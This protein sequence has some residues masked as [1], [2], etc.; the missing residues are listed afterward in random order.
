LNAYAGTIIIRTTF[1]ALFINVSPDGA[2]KDSLKYYERGCTM[3]VRRL[4]A[5][6]VC[7]VLT[8]G[9]TMSVY[10]QD[11]KPIN[12][13]D[14]KLDPSKSLAQALQDRKSTRAYGGPIPMQTLSNLLWAACGIN[15]P[16]SGRR[17]APTAV[18]WQEI[19]VYVVTGEG[20]YLH[21]PKGNSLVPVVSG[22]IRSLT[23]T[24]AHFKDAP[25]HLVYIADLE[26]TGPQEEERKM[27]WIAMD[28][29]FV[30][31]NVYL[32]C[33]V[34]GLPTCFRISIDKEKLGQALKLK[35]TQKIM[36]AQ[37]LGLPKGQ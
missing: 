15:R 19:D 24:Q 16:D 13:P 22:D 3:K 6:I 35:P 9:F 2:R 36:G 34:E 32:Y 25:V 17:T 28:T 37:S 8:I 10:G 26:R 5:G 33:A 30:A 20:A 18:N 23:Y 11:L 21:D 27:P 29:G 14:P 4:T 31:Q 7:L 1:A 12:L